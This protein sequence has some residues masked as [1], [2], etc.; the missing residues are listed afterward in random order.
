VQTRPSSK[1]TE[2]Q[3][4]LNVFATTSAI[5]AVQN[6]QQRIEKAPF[7]DLCKPQQRQLLDHAHLLLSTKSFVLL[8]YNG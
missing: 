7:I 3:S 5:L 4:E 1:I 2:P 6:S 8:S